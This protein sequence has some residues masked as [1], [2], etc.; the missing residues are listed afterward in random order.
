MPAAL[1]SS[2]SRTPDQ[3]TLPMAPAPARRDAHINRRTYHHHR[4]HRQRHTWRRDCGGAAAAAAAAAAAHRR[5]SAGGRRRVSCRRGSGSPRGGCRCTG[6][7]SRRP[8]VP[9][10]PAGRVSRRHGATSARGL[11]GAGVTAGRAMPLQGPGSR[12]P[13]SARP[14]HLAAPHGPVA[15]LPAA[16]RPLPSYLLELGL[17]VLEREDHLPQPRP[18]RAV[19]GERVLRRVDVLRGRGTPQL[20]G[21]LLRRHGS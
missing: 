8:P 5:P 16:L 6:S 17:E 3:R 14:R 12:Q 21:R 9:S 11:R 18:R 13:P 7:P 4:R 2:R 15:P 19:D 10:R 20:S 1:S